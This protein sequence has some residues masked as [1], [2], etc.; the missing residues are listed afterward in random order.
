[1]GKISREGG[2]VSRSNMKILE[3]IEIIKGNTGPTIV[4]GVKGAKNLGGYTCEMRI[5]DN[6]G[7]EVI[8]RREVTEKTVERETESFVLTIKASDTKTLDP[9]SLYI[10]SIEITN[11]LVFYKEETRIGVVIKERT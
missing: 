1:M 6:S 2:V 11:D 8:A 5:I 3:K 9:E 4:L 7:K 10:W